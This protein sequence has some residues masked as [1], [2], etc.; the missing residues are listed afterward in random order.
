MTGLGHSQPSPLRL[1]YEIICPPVEFKSLSW[2]EHAAVQL[3]S[4]PVA[5]SGL[6]PFKMLVQNSLRACGKSAIS[7]RLAVRTIEG[8]SF[9]PCCL[10]VID[11]VVWNLP[12]DS[13]HV[14]Y[15]RV[16]RIEVQVPPG[17]CIIIR[18]F[19][20]PKSEG[21]GSLA[22]LTSA[23]CPNCFCRSRQSSSSPCPRISYLQ[24]RSSSALSKC[25]CPV[26]HTQHSVSSIDCLE[27]PNIVVNTVKLTLQEKLQ[28]YVLVLYIPSSHGQVKTIRE[29]F[30]RACKIAHGFPRPWERGWGGC[31]LFK[32]IVL[33]ATV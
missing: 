29:H 33:Y 5:R 25:P 13:R 21:G 24:S 2:T 23:F 7:D 19:Q 18:Q 20:G 28:N 10:D 32:H 15:G 27:Q 16:L 8:V 6:S 26:L 17:G 14:G 22:I 9:K 1:N 12:V 11:C 31:F 4:G 3:V 30:I